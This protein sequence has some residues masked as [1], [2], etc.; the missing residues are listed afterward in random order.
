MK[1]SITRAADTLL[2]GGI[3]AYPTEGVFGLGCMPD[4]VAALL[5]LLAL[6]RR[7]PRKGLILIA[8]D[9][10]QLDAWIDPDA[11]RI[12]DPD[13]AHPTTWIAPA[14]SHVS[15]LV[16]GDHASLAA[17]L[18]SNPVAAA[19]CAAVESPVVSTSANLAGERVV[20]NRIVL[21][22]KFGACVDYI[23]PG[24]CGP[25]FGASEI[26]NLTTGKIIRPYAA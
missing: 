19:I 8:S 16:T 22:R 5:R 21:R 4:D 20:R 7:D 9:R 26:R 6:K 17:R 13:P 2:R 18:T 3:I 11:S 15:S 24:D 23:V 10:S 12:P 25:S 14:Q 1:L